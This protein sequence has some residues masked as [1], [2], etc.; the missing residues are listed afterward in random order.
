MPQANHQAPPTVDKS[1]RTTAASLGPIALRTDQRFDNA[2]AL[3]FMIV[4]ANDPV[5]AGYVQA[6]Q[7]RRAA[8]R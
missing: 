6:A 2:A 7:A 8:S 5:L 1:G 4:L 3:N